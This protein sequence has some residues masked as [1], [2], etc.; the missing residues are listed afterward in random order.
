MAM[1]CYT[2]YLR[3]AA[4]LVF[5]LL[6]I[7]QCDAF[8]SKLLWRLSFPQSDVGFVTVWEDVPSVSAPFYTLEYLLH[9]L[10]GRGRPLDCDVDSLDKFSTFCRTLQIQNQRGQNFLKRT[11]FSLVSFIQRSWYSIPLSLTPWLWRQGR[12]VSMVTAVGGCGS[13]AR[14]VEQCL[15]EQDTN[16]IVEP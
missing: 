3:M 8:S 11:K 15:V 13:S 4:I 2:F 10:G 6:A 16:N 7:L 12:T 9:S 1:S 14:C 5:Q